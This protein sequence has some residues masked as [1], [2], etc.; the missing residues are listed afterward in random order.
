LA[1]NKKDQG[2]TT[3]TTSNDI[4]SEAPAEGA[5]A[6]ADGAAASA[7]AASAAPAA[8]AEPENLETAQV[9]NKANISKKS[10]TYKNSSSKE[11]VTVQ[12]QS[13]ST[14]SILKNGKLIA[15]KTKPSAQK[16]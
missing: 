7:E 3:N 2:N 10:L 5:A 15:N 4:G 11:T 13:N 12:K 1:K 8:P 14:L 16:N 9:N 6:P